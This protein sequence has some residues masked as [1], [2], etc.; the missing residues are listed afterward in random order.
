MIN[1]TL[2]QYFHWY[3]PAD[4]SLWKKLLSD[5]E[6]LKSLGISSVWLPPAYKGIHGDKSI[7]YDTYDLF[8]LGEFD[9]K[10]S[11]NTKYGNREDYYKAVKAAREAGL[12]VYVDI[13][14]NHKGGA[15]EKEKIKVIR[16]NPD[17]RTESQSEPFDIEAYTKFTFPGRGGQH[18][19]FVWDFNCFSGVD[20]AADIDETGVFKIVNEYGTDWNEVITDEFGN[21][22]YLM[23]AD[24]EFR[25]QA[26]REE[27]KYWI[28]WYNEAIPFDGVRL[29]A[30]KHITPSFFNE[31]LDH[32]RNCFNKDLFSV[33]ECWSTNDVGM[34]HNYIDAT[35]GRTQLFDSVL[36]NRFHIASKQGR[37]FDLA[38]I[39]T[40]T[41]VSTKPEFA[42]TIVANHDTQP[43]QSLEAPVEPWFKPLAYALILM[44]KDGYPCVFYPDLFGA[45]YRDK[46]R[47]GN[48]YDIYMPKTDKIDELLQARQQFAYGDQ[49]DIFDHNN[50]IAWIRHGDEE[51][52]GCIT[53]LSNGEEGFK[54]IQMGED[55]K[56]WG[57]VDFLGNR[58]E[59]I[60][61]DDKGN[62]RFPVNGGS[63]S[64]WVQKQA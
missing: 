26:V 10:G 6:Y 15:D 38:S 12:R 31:W 1:G 50:C 8:D 17:N 42:V 58:Q 54:D 51:H 62:A 30:V 24:V 28:C 21:F 29:D 7:G 13:V 48:E 56:G 16:V 52:A 53:I 36:Q 40:D 47:D 19:K 45:N 49:T 43:L 2:L 46:G 37:D 57:Y 3:Y 64:V 44:R 63:V 25:N 55:K 59:E 61:I 41:L 32:A 22:D 9:Q 11:V 5:L 14:V 60:T 23:H 20:Y 34:L 39:L 18:S 4:G 27:L 35:E 33:A